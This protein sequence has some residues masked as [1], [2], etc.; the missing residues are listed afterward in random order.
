LRF[1]VFFISGFVIRRHL[2]REDI[3]NSQ[4]S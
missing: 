4:A 3:V 2:F 1:G